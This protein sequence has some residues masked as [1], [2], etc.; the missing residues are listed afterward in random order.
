MKCIIQKM[1]WLLLITTL[2]GQSGNL[3]L[4]FWRR[5]KGLGA[6][7]LRDGVYLS[8]E[9][10][11][12]RAAL[13]SLCEELKAASGEAWLV[14]IPEQTDITQQQWQS[15]FD[16]SQDWQ[17]WREALDAADTLPLIEA[18]RKVRQARKAFETLATL[19]F[20]PDETMPNAQQ[21]LIQTEL[22]LAQRDTPDEPTS[23]PNGGIL[24]QDS[25]AFQGRIWATRQR[26]WIDRMACAWLI[27]RFIDPHA[28]FLWLV[29]PKDCPSDAVGFDFD[30][31]TFTHVGHRVTF[32]TLIES[33][34]LSANPA[35]SRLAMLVHY[36]DVGGTLISDAPGIES[37][38]SGLR[39]SEPND[40][41][42]ITRSSEI[43]DW[44]F[45]TY[46][47]HPKGE[48]T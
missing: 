21:A 1:N 4:R 12:L 36:L 20:F 14:T 35:L 47:P 41:A 16:R 34:D 30:G 17:D 32:E 6:A 24:R 48:K 23:S 8:P 40:D 37:L 38:L 26:P 33:F 28:R 29:T 19:D 39:D 42:L 5:L 18:R 22:Q 45:K 10:D 15:L 27:R 46:S 11:D 31:A 44:L 3:R 13:S 7:N 43:F 2:P 25:H 9:R